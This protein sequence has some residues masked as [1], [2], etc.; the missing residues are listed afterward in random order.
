MRRKRPWVVIAAI[1]IAAIQSAMLLVMIERRAEV[2]RD[3]KNILL[4]TK[5][6]D[7]RD[8]MRG[9]YVHLGYEI[10]TVPSNK[11][12]GKRPPEGKSAAIYVTIRAGPDGL[13]HLD[14]ASWQR[15]RGLKE[16]ETMLAGRTRSP[17]HPRAG[18]R[19]TVEYG[20]ERYYI[21]EGAGRRIEDAQRAKRLEAVVAVSRDGRAQIR[22]LREDG[23]AIYEEPF[24]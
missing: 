12:T 4:L 2:L 9:D 7:P 3:G 21:P 11:V 23:T 18:G 6:V 17:F 1:A 16:G 13:W 14:R 10:S 20:I 22:A 19:L 5:P 8:L 24:Y 15:P